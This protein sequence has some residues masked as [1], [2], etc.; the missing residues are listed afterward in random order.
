[1]DLDRSPTEQAPYLAHLWLGGAGLRAPPRSWPRW[2]APASSLT[3][4]RP[5]A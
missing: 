4:R 1:M 2:T 5:A 3:L